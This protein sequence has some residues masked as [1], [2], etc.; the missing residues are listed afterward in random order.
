MTASTPLHATGDRQQ[1]A[2]KLS[3]LVAKIHAT[4]EDVGPI[5][6]AFI[7]VLDIASFAPGGQ[8]ALIDGLTH[9]EA[10]QEVLAFCK[11]FVHVCTLDVGFPAFNAVHDPEALA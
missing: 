3:V 8:H 9:C 1:Q 7:R 10:V 5:T 11:M 6:E 2:A 4:P